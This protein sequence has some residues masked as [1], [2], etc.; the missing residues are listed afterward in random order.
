MWVPACQPGV[1]P[2]PSALEGKVLTTGP[3]G[4][5]LIF[6]VFLIDTLENHF[7]TL[8]ARVRKRDKLGDWDRHIYTIIY[9]IDN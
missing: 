1:E 5:S 2:A 6:I 8:H 4:K 9:K 7:K 3:P